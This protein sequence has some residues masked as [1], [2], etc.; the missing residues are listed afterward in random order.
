MSKVEL[1][2]SWS[3]DFFSARDK[4]CCFGAVMVSNG[5]YGV[6]CYGFLYPYNALSQLGTWVCIWLL[7]H[8]VKEPHCL[9]CF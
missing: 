6:K 9:T 4:Q 7:P 1:G 8:A 2:H 5:E 3:V